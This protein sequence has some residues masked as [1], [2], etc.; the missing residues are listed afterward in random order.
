[1]TKIAPT[2][3]AAHLLALLLLSVS[4]FS[5]GLPNAQSLAKPAV[6]NGLFSDT[7]KVGFGTVAAEAGTQV[8][9]YALY[10]KVYA[11]ASDYDSQNDDWHFDENNYTD[12]N[13]L[14]SGA[15]VPK[16]RGFVRAGRINQNSLPA[17]SF[18]YPFP[19]AGFSIVLDANAN[20]SSDSNLR[21]QPILGL[22]P[23][24]ITD[25]NKIEVARGYLDPLDLTSD[26][27]RSFV[28]DWY[29][30][31]TSSDGD[32][33]RPP[34]TQPSTNTSGSLISGLGGS[35]HP[36]LRIAFVTYAVGVE[37]A[38]LTQLESKP[39]FL[40]YIE[41]DTIRWKDASAR[42]HS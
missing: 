34:G 40:G 41:Y 9:G 24:P 33:R 19:G 28:D 20:D 36:Q 23:D 27:L 12:G 29:L 31:G 21:D 16:Q 11:S 30:V 7:T 10:Y 6:N 35:N 26:D 18:N 38:T 42:N 13:E 37:I 15:T 2:S 1:M 32:L 4:F 25:A 14:A 5:C 22:G 39:I 17:S 3:F 8:N